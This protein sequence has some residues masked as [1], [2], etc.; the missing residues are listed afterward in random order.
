M[1]WLHQSP[2]CSQ[3]GDSRFLEIT[4]FHKKKESRIPL[5]SGGRLLEGVCGP[6]GDLW[7]VLG[8]AWGAFFDALGNL[9]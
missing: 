1:L 9:F 4:I 6:L 7:G 8:P 5:Q 3:L 2:L